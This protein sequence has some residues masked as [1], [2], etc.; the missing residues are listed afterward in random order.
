MARASTGLRDKLYWRQ[1]GNYFHC[2]KKSDGG[3]DSLCGRVHIDRSGGQGCRRPNAWLRCPQCDALE[4][5]RRGWEES[6]PASKE[7]P[8]G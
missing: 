2:F 7:V 5:V 4:A 3:Y 1:A 6:G 8:R